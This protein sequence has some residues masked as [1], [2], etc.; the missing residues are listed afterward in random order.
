MATFDK[1]INDL[2][3]PLTQDNVVSDLVNLLVIVYA[4]KIIP[5]IPRELTKTV[6]NTLFRMIAVFIIIWLGN[7]NPTRSAI[8]A[9]L[10]VVAINLISGRGAFE[11]PNGEGFG[12]LANIHDPDIYYM[13]N[14]AKHESDFRQRSL[15]RRHPNRVHAVVRDNNLR[16]QQILQ[17]DSD[18]NAMPMQSPMGISPTDEIVY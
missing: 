2:L 10:F 3:A 7:R 17:G 5:A 6:D 12:L 18:E 15:E 13:K 11:S 4:T 1:T 8:L 14:R 9:V 16:A